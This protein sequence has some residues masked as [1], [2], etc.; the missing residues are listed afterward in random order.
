[1]LQRLYVAW[2]FHSSL[3]LFHWLL[4]AGLAVVEGWLDLAKLV[5]TEGAKGRSPYEELAYQ[6]GRD[7][8]VDIAGWHLYLRDM[9][10]VPGVK[11]SQALATKLGP[12]VSGSRNGV[13]E[14]DVADVLRR[15]P[16]ELGSGK[17]KARRCCD[18][19]N[20]EHVILRVTL[21]R[22]SMLLCPL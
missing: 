17:T 14:S 13:R 10:A 21:K 1:M 9:S 5:A 6:I 7:V 15:I 19:V 18:F 22:A 16:V 4:F 12:E 2:D 8:Y 20:N 3:A 11:M